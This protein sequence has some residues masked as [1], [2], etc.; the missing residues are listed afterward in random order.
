MVVRV[1]ASG[2]SESGRRGAAPVEPCQTVGA[3]VAAVGGGCGGRRQR[4]GAGEDSS[5]CS[6]SPVL[7]ERSQPKK[8]ELAAAILESFPAHIIGGVS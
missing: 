5:W 6:W 8:K 3:A 2:R 1:Q 4:I 7:V